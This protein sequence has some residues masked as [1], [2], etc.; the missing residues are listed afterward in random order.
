ML[1]F[2]VGI[3]TT[4]FVRFCYYRLY[5]SSGSDP[6]GDVFARI[7]E[8]SREREKEAETQLFAK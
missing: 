2:V 4:F 1:A 8:E 6:I 3:F 5:V 7:E